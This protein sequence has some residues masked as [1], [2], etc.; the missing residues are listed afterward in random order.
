LSNRAIAT[1]FGYRT[2][3]RTPP[4]KRCPWQVCMRN[5]CQGLGVVTPL[6]GTPETLVPS[7]W[8]GYTKV[9]THHTRARLVIRRL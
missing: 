2:V 7:E 3:Y 8:C 6:R 1:R 4:T 9:D 5:D